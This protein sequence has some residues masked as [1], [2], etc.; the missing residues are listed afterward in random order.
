[1]PLAVL[2]AILLVVAYNMGE[3]REIPKLLK[4][5]W[6]T[7]IVWIVTIC[8]TVF[9]DLTIAVQVGVVLAALLFIRKVSATTTVARVTKD[10]IEDGRPH[11]LQDK[12]IPGYVTVIRIHGPFLFGVTDKLGEA[13]GNVDTLAPIVILRLRNMTAVDATGLL[14]IEDLAHQLREA[15]RTLIICGAR[16]QPALIDAAGRR[17]SARRRENICPD[18]QSSPGAGQG[19]F[20]RGTMP[21][22]K[23]RQ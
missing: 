19:C 3:W 17:R 12:V 14:A 10:Y 9:A 2:S 1:M 6:A 18:I 8:L 20:T 15:G 7:R 16:P 11:I 4:M 21:R 13:V 23:N 22:A 5:S